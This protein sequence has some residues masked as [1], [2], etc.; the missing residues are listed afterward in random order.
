[1]RRFQKHIC[2]ITGFAFGYGFAD[3]IKGKEFD[4][5]ALSVMLLL[6][7]VNVTILVLRSDDK[8]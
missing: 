8:D 6:L 2:T 1:M 3:V 4:Q 5:I 7:M